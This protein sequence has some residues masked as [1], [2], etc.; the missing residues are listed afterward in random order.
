MKKF[1]FLA[2]FYFLTVTI[3]AQAPEKFTYQAVVR[4]ASNNLV[5][6]AQVGV[7]VNILQGTASGVTVYSESHIASTNANGLVTVSIGAGSVLQGNFTGIDWSDGPYFLRTDIAPNGGNDYSI[8]SVQQLLSVPYALYAKEAANSFS[9]DYNDLTN[10]PQIPTVPT[11]V[12]AFTN[13]VGYITAAQVPTQVNADWNATT[14]A[15][16]I[17]NKPTLFSGNYN[18]LTNKPTI[19][20]VPTNVSAFTNDAGYLTTYTETDPQFNAWDKDYN[21]L[22][23]KPTIPTVPTNVSAFTNDAGYLTSF[24]EQQVLS[25]SH[26]T[27]FLTGGS[28]VKLPAGFDG[29]YNSLTNKPTIPTVPTN[30]SAFTNDAGF[31]TAGQCNNVDICALIA[32]VSALQQQLEQVESRMDSMASLIAEMQVFP[33]SVTTVPISDVT[34]SSAA[35]GG[36]VTNDGG[37]EVT[38][39]GVCWS[40]SINPTIADSHTADGNGLDSFA[41]SITNLAVGVT[42]YVRA[43][44]TNSVGTAYGENVS[45]TASTLPCGNNTVADHEGNVYNTVQIGSQCWTTENMRCTTSP[46]TGTTIVDANPTATS[47]AGKKA[48]YVNGNNSNTAVYGLLYNWNAALDTFNTSFGETVTESNPNNAVDVVFSSNRRGICPEGWHIPSDAEWTQLSDYVYGQSQYHCPG[49][50]GIYQSDYAPCIAK[51]LASTTGWLNTIISNNCNV[52]YSPS[53]SNNAT[54]FNAVPAG[55]YNGYYGGGYQGFKLAVYFVCATQI[56]GK[57]TP[58]RALLISDDEG[59]MERFSGKDSKNIGTSVR[60]IRDGGVSSWDSCSIGEV[61][62]VTTTAAILGMD[63]STATC[64]GNVNASGNVVTAV[65]VCW[66]TTG[67]PTLSDSH[68]NDGCGV[69]SFTSILTDLEDCATY[70]VRAYA[71]SG[72]GTTYGEETSFTTENGLSC[73]IPTVTTSTAMNITTTTVVCGGTVAG[74]GETAVTARGVCWSTSMNPTVSD[75]HTTD[76]V[77]VGNYISHIVGLTPGTTYYM[78]AYATNSAG[79]A[80]GEHVSF[81][82]PPFLCGSS[83]VADHEGNVYNTVRIGNQCWTKENMRCITSPST[84]TVILEPHPSYR[85]CTGKKAYYVHGDSTIASTYGLLYNWNAAVDTFNTA[86]G[87]TSDET[88]LANVVVASFNGNRR[89][90]C[91][92]GWHVPSDQDWT[93]LT[94]YVRGKSQYLCPGCSADGV[95]NTDYVMCIAKA[96]AS[97]TGW[98]NYNAGD[99]TVNNTP[100]ENNSTGFSALAADYYEY[101]SNP[102]W[103]NSSI[104]SIAY[105]QSSTQNF[106]HYVYH[107]TVIYNTNYVHRG[108]YEVGCGMSVRCL[109]DGDAGY[110][111]DGDQVESPSVK[112]SVAVNVTETSALS[113]GVVDSDGGSPVIARGLC[114]SIFPDPTVSDSHSSDG[115]GVDTFFTQITG[116][117]PGT[118]YYVRAYAI[119]AVG[120]SYG[121]NVIVDTKLPP[122]TFSCGNSTV[123][124]HEGNI[125]H[126]LQIGSQCWTKENMRCKTSPSTGSMILDVEPV[127]NGSFTG[128]KA[129]YA[130][131]RSGYTEEYGL[132]YNWN[133][134]M[135][136]YNEAFGETSVNEDDSNAVNII[137]NGYRRGICPPGWHVPS[138]AEW[139]QL[140]DYVSSQSQFVCGSNSSYI[141]KALAASGW[142]SGGTD[143]CG[144]DINQAANNATGFSI[145]P[146]DEYPYALFGCHAHIWSSSQ[147]ESHCEYA[148]PNAQTLSLY[149]GSP[150]PVY[151]F[152]SKRRGFSVRCLRD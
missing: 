141:A 44:A 63:G 137:F 76:S 120:T 23:N 146:A 35:C 21:D 25:I 90:I 108:A 83:T 37:A 5:I 140:T 54:G 104:G 92:I 59:A 124:D 3:V 40:T 113:G 46:S 111:G 39:Y 2:L 49:C 51:S 18:D 135:D 132:L 129:Y 80:Y 9:G 56:N 22:I 133:A 12:S 119:N 65:G 52:L 115:S 99:C 62:V 11:T 126:T 81:V 50:T 17:L 112:T 121:G 110:W 38:A 109:R 103:N 100:S 13:D 105:F 86:Y 94:N 149:H 74:P 85:S 148:E 6:N 19:P 84:G 69:G 78:R 143:S 87:E 15:A 28:F 123:A 16:E 1:Y 125:Y 7:R 41:S 61:P 24:T 131:E 4:N 32:T 130:G 147:Y 114:W 27:L 91:P 96:L 68:T 97:T 117:T 66:N 93:Q 98:S 73:G 20:T 128:K 150:V 43:Y 152:H 36:S 136:V 53:S 64:G 138:I 75:N 34:T 107:R 127:D 67:S 70:Y 45:F 42:Y 60:C 139:Q 71:I 8:T 55:F 58:L 144:L 142:N 118:R 48:Y 89:G 101:G 116:L 10:T 47:Y 95:I 33:P 30:L 14:G 77:G 31:V 72:T 102:T 88:D 29:D 106:L 79:T 57:Y 122:Q 82:T 145:V 134:A 151:D 26:D